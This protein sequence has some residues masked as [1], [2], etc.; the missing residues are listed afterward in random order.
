MRSE[1]LERA[2]LS[3]LFYFQDLMNQKVD[4][5]DPDLFTTA[6]FKTVAKAIEEHGAHQMLV[7]EQVKQDPTAL[8][9]LLSIVSNYVEQSVTLADL[10]VKVIEPLKMLK[11]GRGLELAA[12]E[13]IAFVKNKEPIRAAQLLKERIEEEQDK[14]ESKHFKT[15]LRGSF[16]YLD[17]LEKL[18]GPGEMD[19][20]V[21][22]GIPLIDSV[23]NSSIGG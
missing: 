18:L 10:D 13:S 20:R 16:E 2:A 15:A 4:P 19:E 12:R 8:D 1:Q 11:F 7:F 9:V 6:G 21:K 22:T 5:I 3:T 17:L 23:M 14:T